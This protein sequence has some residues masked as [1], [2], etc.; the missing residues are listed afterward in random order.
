VRLWPAGAHLRATCIGTAC[1]LLVAAMLASPI[2]AQ[3]G[4][5]RPLKTQNVFLIVSDGLRWQEIFTGAD[6]LLMNHEHGGIWDNEDTLRRAF[7]RATPAER[8]AALFP[9]LWGTVA[10]SGQLI[11]NQLEGSVAPKPGAS[12]DV[13]RTLQILG[14]PDAEGRRTISLAGSL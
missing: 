7:W 11:G 5:P 13:T 4:L 9:F 1:G 2:E 14:P 8:R 3:T 6:S 12:E 10:K